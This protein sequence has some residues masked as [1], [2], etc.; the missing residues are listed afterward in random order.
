MTSPTASVSPGRASPGAVTVSVPY[1]G[2]PATIRRAVD[3]ILAQTH[4]DLICVVTNDGDTE[5]PPWP[6]LAD[7]TDQRLVRIELGHNRGRYFADA[8]VFAACTTPWWTIHDADDIAERDWLEVMLDRAGDAPAVFTAQIIHGQGTTLVEDP[9]EWDGSDVLRHHAHMAGLWRVDALRAAGGPHPEYR[10]GWDTFMTGAM[11]LGPDKPSLVTDCALYH[12]YRRSGSLTTSVS[13]GMQSAIRKDAVRTLRNL[14]RQAVHVSVEEGLP[15]VG[16]LVAGTTTPVDA[17]AVASVAEAIRPVMAAAVAAEKPACP[18]KTGPMVR[19]ALDLVVEPNLWDGPWPLDRG[20]AAELDARLATLRPRVV[21]EAGSGDS[22]LVLARYA[23]ASGA[24]VVSLEHDPRWAAHTAD[25]LAR[26]R[27]GGLVDLRC[28]PLVATDNGP[29]YDTSLPDGIG[30]ALVD[31][32]P[33]ATGGRAA[34]FDALHPHLAS[35]WEVWLDDGDRDMEQAAVAGWVRDYGVHVEELRRGKGL[36]RVTSGPATRPWVAAHD[37][38]V[39]VLTGRRPEHV[40]DTLSTVQVLAPGLLET[41]H[42]VVLHNG[43]DAGTTQAMAAHA[44]VIDEMHVHDGPIL[45]IGPA[46]GKLAERVLASERPY[47]LH[48]EDDWRIVTTCDGWLDDARDVLVCRPDVC[49]VRLRHHG[50]WRRSTHM[51]TGRP[52]TWVPARAALYAADAHLTF[53]PAL[54]R[55]S[56]ATALFPA[57]GEQSAQAQAWAAGL[58]GVAQLAPGVFTHTGHPDSLRVRVEKGGMSR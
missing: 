47:W 24:T 2:C 53:N 45:G 51:A 36:I 12:R 11:F 56:V 25:L 13:T 6:A 10:V 1:H 3:A 15:G 40:A 48:L 49:Q 18:P 26:H 22:T 5:N 41:A 4:T 52:I 28:A 29:W 16:E 54:T 33:E 43:G 38:V 19:Y 42:V 17:E 9:Q 8:A 31:G 32:P 20:V 46:V 39:T 23:A 55:A 34:A 14:W 7:I 30:F 57:A 37:V 44:A 58:R 50:D 35:E 21:V 27:L